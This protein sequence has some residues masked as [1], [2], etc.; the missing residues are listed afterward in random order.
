MPI[1]VNKNYYSLL[2]QSFN[3]FDYLYAKVT[4]F[5]PINAPANEYKANGMALN[6]LNEEL[7]TDSYLNHVL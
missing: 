5:F 2:V 6:S 1:S 4:F 3:R 7:T